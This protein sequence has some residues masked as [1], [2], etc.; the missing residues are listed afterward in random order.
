M[1]D[2]VLC[3]PDGKGGD[4]KGNVAA[5]GRSNLLVVLRGKKVKPHEYISARKKK[6]LASSPLEIRGGVIITLSNKKKI[7]ELPPWEEGKKTPLMRKKKKR[8]EGRRN[9]LQPKRGGP[10]LS[11]NC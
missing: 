6:S 5:L 10:S 1:R 7:G 8:G 4:G 11:R 9:L 3:L 2:T